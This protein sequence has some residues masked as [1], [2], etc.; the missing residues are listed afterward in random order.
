MR[1][2]EALGSPVGRRPS[3]TASPDGEGSRGIGTEGFESGEPLERIYERRYGDLVALSRLTAGLTMAEA[4][5]VVQEVFAGILRRAPKIAVEQELEHYIVRS[6]MNRSRSHGRTEQRRREILR[7]SAGFRGAPAM[8]QGLPE[9]DKIVIQQALET[10]PLRQRSVIVCKYL[11]GHSESEIASL[12][13]MR[14][15]TVKTH[16]KRGL[17]R[18]RAELGRKS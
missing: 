16:S 12:L 11:L 15:G 10:L 18:L 13:E 2:A 9:S 17:I 4:E 14:L 3:T 5:E 8:E 7:D 6:V 1:S